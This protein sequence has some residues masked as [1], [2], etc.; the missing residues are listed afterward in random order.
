MNRLLIY[1][2][3]RLLQLLGIK[4]ER[5][6]YNGGRN[7]QAENIK[8]VHKEGY[9]Y[10]LSLAI[11]SIVVFVQV[12]LCGRVYGGYFLL[13]VNVYNICDLIRYNVNLWAD[14]AFARKHCCIV[15]RG[16]LTMG[17]ES[18]IGTNALSSIGFFSRRIILP[19]RDR[20]L[21]DA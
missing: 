12:F 21:P 8:I 3:V 15:M 17:D 20:V 4:H 13:A 14:L 5:Q 6:Q 7:S 10:R 18:G 16:I 19:R 9:V 2:N 1:P 11:C